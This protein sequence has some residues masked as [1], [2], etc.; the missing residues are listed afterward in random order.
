MLSV[1]V[2]PFVER[3]PYGVSVTTDFR[4]T[5]TAGI[6]IPGFK[7]LIKLSPYQDEREARETFG[8]EFAHFVEDSIYGVTS[9]GFVWT[10]IMT[11]LRLPANPTHRMPL[12]AR[13]KALSSLARIAKVIENV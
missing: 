3:L 2:I 11:T 6:Y 1:E 5:S 13:R 9:H 10:G 12:N 4:M 8:H 7:P